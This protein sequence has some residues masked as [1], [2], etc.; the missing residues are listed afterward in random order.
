MSSSSFSPCCAWNASA[1]VGC[2]LLHTSVFPENRMHNERPMVLLTSSQHSASGPVG[3]LALE[4]Q[5]AATEVTGM[6]F[7][8]P[9]VDVDRHAGGAVTMKGT[10][11]RHLRPLGNPLAWESGFKVAAALVGCGHERAIGGA[12]EATTSFECKL[13]FVVV[14]CAWVELGGFRRSP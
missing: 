7:P 11:H 6:T 10:L 2:A 4:S 12:H 3:K 8:D 5:Q 9:L 1:E 13:D 14:V